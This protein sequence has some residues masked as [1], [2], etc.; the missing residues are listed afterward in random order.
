MKKKKKKKNNKKRLI[1]KI[2]VISLNNFFNSFF[3]YNF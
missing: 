2:Y 1:L 3:I